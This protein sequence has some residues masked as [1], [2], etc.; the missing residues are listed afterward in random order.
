[1]IELRD[2]PSA[3][4]PLRIH[5][6]CGKRHFPG[7]VHVDIDKLPQV[8]FVHEA[9]RLPM[10]EAD[11]ADIIYSAH[12][13]NYYTPE[14]AAAALCEW[15]RVLK[16]G[17]ILRLSTPDFEAIC[18]VYLETRDMS[19]MYGL[20]NGRYPAQGGDLYY[21][22]AYDLAS[23]THA[24]EG[25]GF[26]DVRRYDWRLT[27]HRDVDDY[28]QAYLPHMDK[29]NGTLMSLNVEATK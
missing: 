28:S 25:A 12:Q 14:Q 17:G 16:P 18:R 10:F 22:L 9:E 26:H 6:A 5:L 27:E 20:V 23:L 19:R 11:S 4:L 29:N 15:R 24:L 8:D 13:F 7:W 1:M 21:R 2:E 3:C